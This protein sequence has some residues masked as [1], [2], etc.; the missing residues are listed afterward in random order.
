MGYLSRHS[1][2]IWKQTKYGLTAVAAST[3]MKTIA[4][5]RKRNVEARFALN[6]YGAS[7]ERCSWYESKK[8]LCEFSK[9][10]PTLVFKLHREGE[11]S[12]DME[13]VYFK[14]GK[15]QICK[16][17]MSFGLF[18]PEKLRDLKEGEI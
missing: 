18:K 10:R 17:V 1:L 11:E 3:Q 2:T 8:D 15:L 4:E 12:G 14:N 5:L 9:T 16:I 7:D 13:H 6:E